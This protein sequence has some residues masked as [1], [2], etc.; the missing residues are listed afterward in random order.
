MKINKE[1]LAELCALD[2]AALWAQVRE[3]ARMHGFTLPDR[4]PSHTE[5][6]KL[7][8]AVRGGTK[9]NLQEALKIIN[10]LRREN[11]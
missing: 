8:G 3:I 10:K 1:K 2:D 5:M 7:R 11:G 6:E 4:T 9:M